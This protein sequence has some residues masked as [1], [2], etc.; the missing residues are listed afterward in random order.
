MAISYELQILFVHLGARSHHGPQF[1][2]RLFRNTRSIHERI[3]SVQLRSAVH[4]F[5]EPTIGTVLI[6]IGALIVLDEHS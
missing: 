4:E 5:S 6:H 1:Q 2:S 3:A